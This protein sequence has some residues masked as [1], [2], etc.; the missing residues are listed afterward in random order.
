MSVKRVGGMNELEV[1]SPVMTGRNWC[2][3]MRDPA[4]RRVDAGRERRRA[5]LSLCGSEKGIPRAE[6]SSL[7][8]ACASDEDLGCIPGPLDHMMACL[9]MRLASG[10]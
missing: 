10:R 1:E 2:I 4:A 5:S 7:N 8:C 6:R 3:R 9:M